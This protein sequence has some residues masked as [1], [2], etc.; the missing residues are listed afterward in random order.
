[1]YKSTYE[2]LKEGQGTWLKTNFHTHAGICIE[3]QCG[4][5][6]LD[7]VVEA[8]KKAGCK[9]LAI[10][11]HNRYIPQAKE[12]DNISILDAVEYSANPHMLLIGVREFHDVPHQEAIDRAVAAGGFV[13]LCHPNWQYNGYF[14]NSLIDSLK[15]YTGI[16]IFNG[17]CWNDKG[18]GLALDTWD[19][20]LSQGKRTWGFG[21][22]DFHYYHHTNLAYN[23]IYAKSG[24]YEDI[25]EAVSN[26]C[27]YV[28]TGVA[29]KEYAL[30]GEELF[31]KG[32]YFQETYVN[33]FEYKFTGVQGRVLY[34]TEG[35]SA[36]FRI[37]DGEPY[38]RV[39]VTA[40]YGAKMYLQPVFLGNNL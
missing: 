15:G 20:V 3:G 11:N 5:H 10:S 35:D 37:P 27:F 26:G 8:Y 14:P 24:R 29:L 32:G 33:C 4:I 7:D 2:A 39:E 23:M 40:D 9:V 31:V 28:S 25:K 36:R 12:Y 34:K 13:I 38:V 30:E 1:M 21:N 6:P 17:E 19:H 22:D 18:S 16:E